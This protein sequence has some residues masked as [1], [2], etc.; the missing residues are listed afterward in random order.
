MGA[1]SILSKGQGCPLHG[2][3]RSTKV[4]RIELTSAAA[5]G[6]ARQLRSLK[7]ENKLYT[8]GGDA[9]VLT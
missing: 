2:L 4:N 1:I 9:L 7:R 8:M 5:Q 6:G 3:D